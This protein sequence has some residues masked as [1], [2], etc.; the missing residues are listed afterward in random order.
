MR[1]CIESCVRG[2]F[3]PKEIIIS[4]VF[5]DE[6]VDSFESTGDFFK[7]SGVER[8]EKLDIKRRINSL[9]NTTVWS[10][11]VLLPIFYYTIKLCVT[12]QLYSRTVI[13]SLLGI[14]ACKN[15]LFLTTCFTTLFCFSHCVFLHRGQ[16]SY[17]NEIILRKIK[18]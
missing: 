10:I 11:L 8:L 18:L 17:G 16:E 4:N 14:A 9:I 13:T 1:T 2:G 3:T 12:G 5:Q 15:I 7:T 6:I